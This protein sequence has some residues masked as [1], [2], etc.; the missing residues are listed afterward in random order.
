MPRANLNKERIFAA[1]AELANQNGF[2][3][4]SL[5]DI[6]AHFGVKP[7]SLFKHLR[8]LAEV[9]DALAVSGM[10]KLKNAISVATGKTAA[11]RLAQIMHAY[12][13][14]AKEF[15]G[16]YDA[17]QETH[18]RRS[19][20]VNQLGEEVLATFIAALP[21]KQ[22]LPEKIH[23]LRFLRSALHGFIVLEKGRGFGLPEDVGESFNRMVDALIS[24]VWGE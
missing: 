23:N 21:A 2:A 17:F 12:R 7:P 18:V 9:R 10:L 24:I 5:K 20:Q 4:L 8:D 11:D 16:E 13:Q 14:F 15:P 6:A 1:A 22:S 19:P 3:A